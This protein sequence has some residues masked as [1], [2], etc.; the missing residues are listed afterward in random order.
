MFQLTDSYQFWY[1]VTVKVPN[2]EKSGAFDEQTFEVLFDALSA[3]EGRKMDEER[4]AAD[5]AKRPIFEHDF[6]QRVVKDWRNVCD[7]E[8]KHVNFSAERLTQALQFPWARSALWIAY[9][10]AAAGEAAAGN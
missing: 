3:D 6:L 5:P 8:K 7:A 2:P 9:S 10:R 4:A 1:P